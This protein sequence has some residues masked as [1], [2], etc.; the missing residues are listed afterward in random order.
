MT[1]REGAGIRLEPETHARS[2][3]GSDSQAWHLSWSS[4]TRQFEIRKNN[5]TTV[6]LWNGARDE[7]V[8]FLGLMYLLQSS[9]RL[10]WSP[11]V[12]ASDASPSGYAVC[13]EQW[14]QQKVAQQGRILE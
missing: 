13:V 6:P 11:I 1:P 7:L 3:M 12:A 8:C 10:T 2:N 9:W 4:G 5:Y 14:P